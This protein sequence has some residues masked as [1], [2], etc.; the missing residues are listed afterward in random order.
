MFFYGID[1]LYLMMM[2]PVMI[3]SG[4]TSLKVRTSFNKFSK[5]M[6]NSGLSGADVAKEILDDKF[7]ESIIY[8]VD[9]VFPIEED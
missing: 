3:I 1:P 4:I 8:H 9:K 5:V 2:V 6:S 7:D